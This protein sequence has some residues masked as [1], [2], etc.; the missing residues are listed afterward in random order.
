MPISA[1]VR[2]AAPPPAADVVPQQHGRSEARLSI[3]TTAQTLGRTLQFR[4]RLR[5]EY[6]GAFRDA[7]IKISGNFERLP[8]RAWN[9]LRRDDTRCDRP[10]ARLLRTID[11][12][13]L[14]GAE[15]EV[16]LELPAIL[17]AYIYARRAQLERTPAEGVMTIPE[18]ARRAA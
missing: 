4:D 17:T 8:T 7:L 14:A 5:I 9:E 18:P 16:L 6:D 12:A 10:W 15:E 2:G 1:R 13:C 3:T 11:E